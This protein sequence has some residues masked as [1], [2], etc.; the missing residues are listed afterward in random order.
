MPY[1]Q[2]LLHSSS[3]LCL[4]MFIL[5]SVPHQVIQPSDPQPVVVQGVSMPFEVYTYISMY[6]LLLLTLLSSTP[7]CCRPSSRS[8]SEYAMPCHAMPRRA[9]PPRTAPR[10]SHRWGLIPL[11]VARST[12][13]S[14]CVISANPARD[15]IYRVPIPLHVFC[16]P[17][18]SPPLGRCSRSPLWLK[19]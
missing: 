5:P 3:S 14:S 4:P 10:H 19:L 6:Y 7:P 9:S 16:P 1:S 8:A 11:H 15:R 13:I 17:S 12:E 2:H 18:H